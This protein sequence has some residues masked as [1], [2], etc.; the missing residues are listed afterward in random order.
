MPPGRFDR[1]FVEKLVYLPA[2]AIFQ[3]EPA[4]P[5]VAALPALDAGHLTF[6]SFNRLGKINGATIGLWSQLLRALPDSRLFLAGIPQDGQQT[7]FIRRF[8][9]AGVVRE[10]IAIHPRGP[11]DTYLALH[12]Q[13]D[14]CLDTVPYNGGTTTHHAL[15]MGVPT[16]TVAGTTPAGRQ[17]AGILE[18]A[19]LAEFIAADAAD[20]VA[21]GRHWAARLDVLAELRT[22]LRERCRR[23]PSQR[24]DVLVAG[25]EQAF[26]RMWT[27]WCAGL[28]AESF[29]IPAAELAS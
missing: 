5:Q 21:K 16:L 8:A 27:R 2:A 14:I 17:G 25:L 19:G 29:E 26:R 23:S 1:H 24:P 4:A 12:H 3:P 18:L 20:F 7:E 10:R 13:V 9:K 11:M 28:P 22:G 6:G 15:W